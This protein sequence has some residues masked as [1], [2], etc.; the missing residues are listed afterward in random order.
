[1]KR[2]L[3][4]ILAIDVVGYS[5]LMGRDEAGT[6][7]A[8]KAHRTE[9]IEPKAAQ[10][11]G[12]TIKLMGDGALMEFASVVDAVRFAV[13][14]QCAMRD[15]NVDVAAEQR[16][17]FRVGINVG[18]V[19]AEDGDIHGDGV[20]VA[21]RIEA[22]ARPGGICIRRNV[23]N[24][25]RD[26]LD[27]D[28]EDMGE[29]EVKNIERPIRAFQI[30][31]NEKAAAFATALVAQPP[32]KRSGQW[33]AAVAVFSLAMIFGAAWW[34]PW[35]P[36][37]QPVQAAE[38][39]RPL[40]DRPSIAVLA[41]DDLS[42]GADQGYLSDAI[43][44]EVI[45]KLSRFSEF[46][47]IARSS[48]FFYKGKATDVRDIATELG[49]RYLLQGS[50]QKADDRLRVS[51]QL[52]DATA[53]NH[54]WAETYDR[55]LADIFAVQ[56]EITRTIVATLAQ[57]LNLAEFDRLLRQPT[58]SLTAYELVNR[59]RAER[60]KFTPEGHEEAK[61]L[62][63]KALELDPSYSEAYFSLTWVHINC[64]RWGWC[65]PRPRETAL[66]L[67]F[68]TARKAVELDPYS[69]LAHWALANA[70]TQSG[71]LEQAVVEYDRAIALNINSAS[72]L[73]DSTEPLVFLGRANDAVSRAK[74]AIRLSPHHPDWYLWSLGWAQYFAGDYE[75]GLASLLSMSN[76]PNMANRTLAALY[77]RLGRMDEARATIDAFLA[78]TPDYT[79][80]KQWWS[81]EGKF[82]DPKNAERFIDDLRTAGLPE[83]VGE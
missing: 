43:S 82:R 22:L 69:H 13:E 30:V 34:Q 42:Q 53:G 55:D 66:D 78:E 8:L 65:G 29:I 46:F 23:R 32:K 72:V 10:Y 6:L 21:A 14:V 49:I 61:R 25:V 18:D 76:M 68:E 51:V 54:I 15:R 37:F 58:D 44:E 67:A 19:I 2:R 50:Q 73:V 39:E 35:A 1:M 64:F 17:E 60:L 79:I 38:M 41:F 48:S 24:Q 70:T 63:E 80:E 59:S 75:G 77:V 81:L 28:L 31:M 7:A 11:G 27:L 71:D 3:A 9:L 26:K 62:A 47:V 16:I 4:A 57:N 56:D 12:Q 36:E 45:N 20:N 40:P 33:W 83:G 52:I 5:R 74:S